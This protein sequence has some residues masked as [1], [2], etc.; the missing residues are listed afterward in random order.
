MIEISEAKSTCKDI[1]FKEGTEKFG[2]C[3]LELTK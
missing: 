1:G 3:V 2:E